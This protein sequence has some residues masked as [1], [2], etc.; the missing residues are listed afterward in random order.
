MITSSKI[1]GMD[2]TIIEKALKNNQLNQLIHDS[3]KI[4][5]TSRY[6]KVFCDT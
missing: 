6:Y 4:Y 5:G 2:K 3:C 1:K